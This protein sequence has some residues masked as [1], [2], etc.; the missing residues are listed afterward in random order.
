MKERTK[1]RFFEEKRSGRLHCERKEYHNVT[2][3]TSAVQ[4]FMT[5]SSGWICYTSSLFS[6]VNGQQNYV[7]GSKAEQDRGF[8]LS[9][10]LTRKDDGNVYTSLHV[11]REGRGW[12]A[13]TYTVSD[14]GTTG[15]EIQY[16]DE[17]YFSSLTYEGQNVQN[18]KKW[19]Y[20]LCWGKKD[21][22]GDGIEVCEPL[23]GVLIG[24][25]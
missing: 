12:T 15:T 4:S 6:V 1:K 23:V 19:T 8:L 9:C 3:V 13:Y 16:F 21:Q 22:E 5:N 20:R 7:S 2:E 17:T 11:R 24:L 14:K 18:P 10:E 25:H